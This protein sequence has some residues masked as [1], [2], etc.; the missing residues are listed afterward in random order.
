MKFLEQGFQVEVEFTERSAQR[1]QHRGSFRLLLHCLPFVRE[2]TS[3][4]LGVLERRF[5]LETLRRIV[6]LHNLR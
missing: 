2:S 6:L 4:S 3:A 1:H 5:C